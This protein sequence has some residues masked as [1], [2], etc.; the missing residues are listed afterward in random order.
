MQERLQKIIARAGIASRRKAEEFILQGRVRVNG[1]VV[2]EL[3]T[4]ADAAEDSI[5]I[6]GKRINAPGGEKLYLMLNK[7]KSYISSTADPQGRPT[8][9]DLLGRYRS[10]VYPIGRL[11]YASEGLLLFTNDGDF[12]N[13]VLSAKSAIPK[14][15]QVKLNGNPTHEQMEKFC[16]GVKIDGR[17]TAPARARL[18]KPGDNPWFEVVLTE[19]RNQQVRRMFRRLGFLV[20]KLKRVKVGRVSL[21]RLPAGELR[22]LKEREV[23]AIRRAA[24]SRETQ[25]A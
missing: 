11:D 1:R 23:D 21:G 12:A 6:N 20:E 4:K 19:G 18:S 16:A 3:G 9:M 2:T 25:A 14:V 15:Y 13:L 22:P 10:R 7:P 24:K 8:V 5:K 17:V